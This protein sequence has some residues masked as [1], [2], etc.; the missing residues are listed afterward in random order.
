VKKYFDFI[1][2]SNGASPGISTVYVYLNNTTTSATI[3]SDNGT[4]T[5]SNPISTGAD[6]YFEFFAADGLYTL[7]VQKTGYADRTINDVLLEDPAYENAGVFSTITASGNVTLGDATTD[8]LNVGAGGIIKDSSGRVGIG[9]TPTARDNTRLQIVDGVGFPATQVA[10]TDPNTLDDY[11]EGTYTG[12]LTGCT[13]SPTGTFAYTKY[14]NVVTLSFGGF[15]ALT[16]TSNSVNCTVTG[17]PARM[18]PATGKFGLI[19]MYNNSVIVV[20]VIFVDTDG[21]FSIGLIDG[22]PL[23]AAGSKGILPFSISYLIP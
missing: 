14:G 11:A 5:K 15:A 9:V 21:S 12:T 19:R 6:G 7:K 3:Y 1:L 16:G 2:G 22:T 20:G 18:R 4:T 17:G 13:T 10:S 23:T 8:T